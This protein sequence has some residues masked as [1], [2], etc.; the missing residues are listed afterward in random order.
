MYLLGFAAVWWL[1]KRR[2]HRSDNAFKPMMVSDLVFYGALGAVLGGRIG[3]IL[4]YRLDGLLADPLMLLRIWE[5]GMSFHGGL[6]GVILGCYLY[7]RRYSLSFIQVTDFVAPLVPIGLGLG[8]IG[9]FINTELPGRVT[10]AVWGLHYPCHVVYLLNRNCSAFGAYEIAA[11]HPSALY[12]AFAEGVVLLIV[13]LWATRIPR[14]LGFASGLFI[15]SYGILRVITENFRS[16][17]AH[18]G[19]FFGQTVTMGQML[20]LP[21]IVAGIAWLAVIAKRRQHEAV[22]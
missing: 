1:G 17:D 11:R 4:F 14:P 9:N 20:S 12:Q 8:R 19:F 16:P 7:G 2:A 6:I 5:G 10:D 18:L 22:S 13:M 21:L 3:Y 15:A